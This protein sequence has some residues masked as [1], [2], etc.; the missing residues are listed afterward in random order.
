MGEMQEKYRAMVEKEKGD[1]EGPKNAEATERQTVPEKSVMVAKDG[2]ATAGP[3]SR[4]AKRNRYASQSVS[5]N[6]FL[7]NHSDAM[8]AADKENASESVH[9][10]PN[11]KKRA[12][13]TKG[14]SRQVTNPS[15]VLSPKSAN[16]RTLPQSPVRP[17]MCSPQKSHLSHSTSPLKHFSPVKS[18]S[19]A[20]AAAVAATASLASLVGE[21]SKA[22][23]PKA[24]TTRK[25]SNS[26]TT[27]AATTRGKRGAGPLH[28]P[29]DVRKVSNTS[30]LSSTSAGTTIVVN[31]K[32]AP[33]AA[34]KKRDVG[35]R[36]IGKKVTAGAEAP[37][38]ARRVLRKRA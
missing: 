21:K 11:P 14:P 8:E 32:K 4:T 1:V 18:S 2:V 7:I 29:E 19:P 37:A 10:I 24:G 31:S 33:P 22:G 5:M 9:D 34:S 35:V 17:A 16:S 27:K 26:A 15:T 36:A 3:P 28:E 23:R 13:V 6:L 38:P 30:N 25:A 20:K 12:K